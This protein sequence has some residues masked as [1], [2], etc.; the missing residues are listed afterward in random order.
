ML[1]HFGWLPEN[2]ARCVTLIFFSVLTLVESKRCVEIP[3]LNLPTT[4]LQ[5]EKFLLPK[6]KWGPTNQVLGMLEAIQ[7]AQSSN[8]TL[9]IPPMFR[10]FT[11][12]SNHSSMIDMNVRMDVEAIARQWP[13]IHPASIS[14]ICSNGIE[15]IINFETKIHY[16]QY[17]EEFM[18][19]FNI[20]TDTPVRTLSF[21]KTKFIATDYEDSEQCVVLL[22]PYRNVPIT[23]VFEKDVYDI[24]KYI[25]EMVSTIFTKNIDLAIHYRFDHGDWSNRCLPSHPKSGSDM[26]KLM[27][28][29]NHKK[30]AT[31]LDSLKLEF[32][33]TSEKFTVFIATPRSNEGFINKTKNHLRAMNSTINLVSTSDLRDKLAII[34][35]GCQDFEIYK[36]EIMSLA[37]QFICSSARDFLR[38]GG[39]S[40]SERA[41]MIRNVSGKSKD[42]VFQEKMLKFFSKVSV[43]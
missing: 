21:K 31:F 9:I 10:H 4:E 28:K 12:H 41:S 8:R 18:A 15:K 29:M 35:D 16:G 14:D 38:W 17:S 36:H 11:E 30:M 7:F 22:R 5:N 2:I 1:F 40:W 32:S 24:P 39:S 34:N 6:L 3:E 33:P 27:T 25:K 23:T 42:M 43:L 37:D 19:R 13:A 20:S 26:C